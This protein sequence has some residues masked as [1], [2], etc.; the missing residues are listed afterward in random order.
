[1]KQLVVAHGGTVRAE[2][3]GVGQGATFVV[4][5]PARL[6]SRAAAADTTAQSP[7]STLPTD[8]AGK[9]LEGLVVLV[10][11][12]EDDALQV[13]SRVLS[14]HGAR[15]HTAS[16]AREAL[17]MLPVLRPDVLVSDIGMPG[18]DGYTLLRKVRALPAEQGGHTLAVALTAYARREDAQRAFAAGYQR[19]VA[20]PIEPG[21]LA[22]V[23]ANLKGGDA[24]PF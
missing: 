2:S 5:L 12:D 1:V 17:V 19:H 23:V 7:P 20:K 4:E 18:E 22:N 24:R 11:D 10:V 8:G 16:S 6:V 14:A 15:V 13:E 21:E 3:A 9:R